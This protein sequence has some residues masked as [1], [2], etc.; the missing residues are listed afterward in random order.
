MVFRHYDALR[1]FSI[2]AEDG[3]F[4]SAADRLNLSKGAVSYQIKQL[5]HA[6]GFELF[7]RKPRGVVLTKRGRVLQ[8]SAARA[9]RDIDRDILELRKAGAHTLVI[10]VTSYFA[11]RWL[12][13]RLTTFMAAHPDLRLRLQPVVNTMDLAEEGVD[14]AVR[15]GKGSWTD[16]ASERLFR[17]PAFPTGNSTAARVVAEGGLAEA[18]ETFTLLRD[19]DDSSAWIDWFARAGLPYAGE[20]DTLIIPDPNVRVQAVIDGQGVGLNDGLVEPEL[21]AGKLHRLSEDALDDYGYFLAY[22]PETIGRADTRDFVDW[23]VS[24]ARNE[25]SEVAREI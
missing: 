23:M 21:V 18:M 11:S 6:L 14:L 4:A 25:S 10:G 7:I 8:M 3:G 9:F 2:V 1:V 15:W 13:P 5:E 17:C 19:R 16:V 22:Y 12:S 20:A 24:M